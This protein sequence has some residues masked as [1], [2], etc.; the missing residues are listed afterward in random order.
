MATVQM[1]QK[2]E[3]WRILLFASK[4]S[5]LLV[6]RRLSGFGLPVLRIPPQERIA[7]SLNEEARR[8]WNVETICVAPCH[9]PDP[10]R[11]ST[12]P[13][14]Y[15]M[16]VLNNEDLS[17]IAPK[18][19]DVAALNENSFADLRDYLAVRRAM[20]LDA[21]LHQTHGPFSEFATFE[22]ISTW[23][24]QQLVPLERRWD[25]AFRQL[26]A[27]DAFALIRFQT[28]GSAVWFKATGEPNRRELAIT[29]TLAARF[30]Q[31][32]PRIIAVRRDWNAWL[33]DEIEG[34]QLDS[35]QDFGSWCCA[36]RTL[37]ELQ[38][39]SIGH[40][41]PILDA[42]AHDSRFAKLHSQ[43]PPFFAAM[44]ELMEAQVKTP[45]Q[46]LSSQEMRIVQMQLTEAL[47]AL[48][49][50][51]IPDALNHFD[52]NP[53]NV[54]V[55]GGKSRFLDWAE[56]AI[57]NPFFTFEYL[58]QHYLRALPHD[59][60]TEA[61]FRESY[62]NVWRSLV[63]QSKIE[64]ATELVPLIA[65]FAFAVTLSWRDAHQKAEPKVAGFLRSLAR[66]MQ[67]E[68]EQLTRCA[69]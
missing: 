24:A 8:V 3:D 63:P 66:R 34:T 59:A 37:A 2:A 21:D 48:E 49:A 67:R 18:A 68:A 14:Y 69:A 10:N 44:E 54:I 56:T 33:S 40:T 1:E 58:R 50:T 7:A 4:G 17:R 16:E 19:M 22:K 28:N 32:V 12:Q 9:I 39:G 36:A 15:V 60:D 55:G 23:V 25:G 13:R 42:G 5:E 51:G 38:V 6:L 27:S 62:V 31:Y 43:I 61:E 57:G 11:N 26:H 45:P 65:P 20:N 29:E 35:A 30:P 52:L 46:R 41:S 64:R 47:G 53:G